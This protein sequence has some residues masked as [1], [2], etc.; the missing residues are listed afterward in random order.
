MNGIRN[1]Y[2][3]LYSKEDRA[4]NL[5]KDNLFF[6]KCNKLSD[7]NKQRMDEQISLKDMYKALTSCK[8]T[9]PGPDGIPYLV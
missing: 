9:A 2:Q 7:V 5:R 8:N 6:K 1:F 4:D 3:K